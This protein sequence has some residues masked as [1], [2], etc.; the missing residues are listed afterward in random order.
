M[1]IVT[2]G[3]M[4]CLI[5]LLTLSPTVTLGQSDDAA[6]NLVWRGM[7]TFSAQS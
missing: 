5:S 1:K 7:R 6:A 2:N 4:G 3:A